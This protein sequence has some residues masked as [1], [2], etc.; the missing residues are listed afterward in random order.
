MP[1]GGIPFGA[2]S[3]I[4]GE[5]DSVY[6]FIT[7]IAVIFFIIT[8]GLL[9]YF[10]VKYRRRK[11]QPDAETPDIRTNRVLEGIWVAIPTALVMAIFAYG[12][13]VFEDIRTPLPG[14]AEIGVVGKQW[15][16]E[17]KYPDGRTAINE[18]RVPVGEPVQLTMTSKDVIHGFF[19]PDFRIKQDVL[20]GRYTYLWLKPEK[21]G[22][23]NVFCSQYCGTGHS[24]MLAKLIVMP[25]A[26]YQAWVTEQLETQKKAMPPTERGKA[27]VD[28]LGCL[29]CH[30]IDGTIK[31]G[32]SY[33][34]LYG[35]R[36]TLA[37]GSQVTA[38]DNYIRE[39]ILVPSAKI[40]KGFPNVMPPFQ[41]IVSDEDVT[42][43]IAYLKTM[44]AP[45]AHVE[46]KESHERH[47]A[48]EKLSPVE[49]REK[50]EAIVRDKGC[51]AC[52]STD[53]SK[54][55]GPTFKGLYG[56]RVELEGGGTAVADDAYIK[57]SI[58]EPGA[59]VV[60]GYQNMMP[61]FKGVL[62][63]DDAS[64]V[65]EYIKSLK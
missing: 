28:R 48:A 6:I 50:G 1:E 34:G 14:A 15:L 16:W 40:V 24:N 39:S 7:T 59:K 61:S 57:E 63:E 3:P 32:P 5:V 25:Q 60:K 17:F 38:D 30:S 4:A 45:G 22:T 41:G 42:A 20:P 9:I 64:A 19:I 55:V 46:E 21:V 8:Q 56:R 29:A 12:Y 2:A 43:I 44:S 62:T 58:F 65:A 35:S 36:V 11:G 47:E 10:A 49:F 33:K 27:L 23:Y 18:L 54:K 53:G 26:E 37:D 31:V 51:G 13:K 52:H